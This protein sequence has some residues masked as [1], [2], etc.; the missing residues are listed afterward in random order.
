MKQRADDGPLGQMGAAAER[1]VD[2]APEQQSVFGMA[3]LV[4]VAA[5]KPHAE[6]LEGPTGQGFSQDGSAHVEILAPGETN[7][8]GRIFPVVA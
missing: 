3:D 1:D 4:N 5:G 2:S 8:Q 6:R 7:L